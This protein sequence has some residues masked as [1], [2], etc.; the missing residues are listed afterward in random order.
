MAF[1][2]FDQQVSLLFVGAGVLALLRHQEPQ[3]DCAKNLEKLL[4]ALPDYG[5]GTVHVDGSALARFGLREQDL[6][7]P[8]SRIDPASLALLY[9][10]HEIV[11]TV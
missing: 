7:L 2:A 1:G 6:A 4:G 9:A 5:I 3:G 11:L 10:A 8:V